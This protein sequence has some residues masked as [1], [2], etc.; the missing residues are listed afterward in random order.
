MALFY[1][2]Y[3]IWINQDS[4][5]TAPKSQ[6]LGNLERP[7]VPNKEEVKWDCNSVWTH[8]YVVDVLM[9]Q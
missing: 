8:I 1:A 7:K 2:I 5:W 9:E 3:C 4:V 6:C